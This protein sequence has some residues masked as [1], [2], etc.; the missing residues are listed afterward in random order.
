MTCVFVG[1]HEWEQGPDVVPGPAPRLPHGQPTMN[2]DVTHD[3]TPSA[4]LPRGR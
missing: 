1:A 3:A 4:T 2:N